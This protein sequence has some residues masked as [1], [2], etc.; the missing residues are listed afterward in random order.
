MA[1]DDRTRLNFVLQLERR[2]AFYVMNVIV[3]V[4]L[5]SLLTPM[6]FKL[7]SESGERVS[8]M[9]TVVLALEVL[10]TVVSAH[11]PATS[12]HISVIALLGDFRKTN[13][14]FSSK[15]K[16][17]FCC[18]FSWHLLL[19]PGCFAPRCSIAGILRLQVVANYLRMFRP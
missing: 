2:Y 13:L 5:T 7:P 8:F 11:M 10:L 19:M 3:P 14:F 6:V 18:L 1:T 17:I 16:L 9:L 12:L 15:P 4:L